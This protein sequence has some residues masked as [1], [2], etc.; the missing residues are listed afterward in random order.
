M[1]SEIILYEV[2]NI[3]NNHICS[4]NSFTLFSVLLFEILVQVGRDHPLQYTVK[5]RIYVFV[6][7]T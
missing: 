5:P 7:T 6:G 2:I 1:C 4:A 3:L